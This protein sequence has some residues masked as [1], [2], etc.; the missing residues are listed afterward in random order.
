MCP[1]KR[2]ICQQSFIYLWCY[3][4]SKWFEIRCSNLIKQPLITYCYLSFDR[5]KSPLRMHIRICKLRRRSSCQLSRNTLI[6]NSKNQLI[7]S[8]KYQYCRTVANKIKKFLKIQGQTFSRLRQRISPFVKHKP[9][10]DKIY[11]PMLPNMMPFSVDATF[12][13]AL[14]L[15]KSCGAKTIGW[16]FSTSLRSP[17]VASSKV[18]FCS[19]SPTNSRICLQ[20]Y[21]Q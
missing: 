9:I 5:L 11:E 15:Q 3:S 21:Q 13:L 6:L 10:N 17:R 7:H 18:Q 16:G 19:V 4:I 1:T 2:D 8:L 12:T 14:I 20:Q